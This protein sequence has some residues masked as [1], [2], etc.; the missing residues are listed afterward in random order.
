MFINPLFTLIGEMA[1]PQLKQENE[2]L[3][4]ENAILRKHCL[5]IRIILTDAEK[6]ILIK[7]GRPLGPRL[8]GIIHVVKYRS[9]RRWLGTMHLNA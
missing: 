6:N 3:K 4:A 5:R 8:K 7:L 9:F 1:Y 2:F